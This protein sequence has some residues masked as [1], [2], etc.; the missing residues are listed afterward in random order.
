VLCSSHD[1]VRLEDQ[2][3]PSVLV[4]TDV[5]LETARAH[6][7]ALGM[8]RMAVVAI[9]NPL[10]GL[11]PQDVEERARASVEAVVAALTSSANAGAG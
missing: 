2:Q 3:C 10:S 5:F 11:P 7:E 6:A 8:P 9:P 4:C 1:V